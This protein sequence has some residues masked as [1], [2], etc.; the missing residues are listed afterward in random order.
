MLIRQVPYRL[1]Y[2]PTPFHPSFIRYQKSSTVCEIK[3]H[4]QT[5]DLERQEAGSQTQTLVSELEFFP[6]THSA[7][8]EI[9]EW[10]SGMSVSHGLGKNQLGN[11]RHIKI[12]AQPY[13][14]Q[15]Q[16]FLSDYDASM[17]S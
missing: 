17:K 16:A 6:E 9:L 5:T 11:K 7:V 12:K 15:L 8:H 14:S 2:L 13:T 4:S 10:E 3:P 1:S